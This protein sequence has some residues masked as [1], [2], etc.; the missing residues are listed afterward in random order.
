MDEHMEVPQDHR[1]APMIRI[2]V[3]QV[4]PGKFKCETRSGMDFRTGVRKPQFVVA[5]GHDP[6]KFMNIWFN[7][8]P[9]MTRGRR[10]VEVGHGPIY[11]TTVQDLRGAIEEGIRQLDVPPPECPY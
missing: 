7:A 11:Y 2:M 4:A 6:A 9:F 10:A 8:D 5:M 3:D 1:A